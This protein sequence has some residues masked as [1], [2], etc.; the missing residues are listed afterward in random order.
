MQRQ[1]LLGVV[2]S[3]LFVGLEG[4]SRIFS[5]V[6]FAVHIGEGLGDRLSVVGDVLREEWGVYLAYGVVAAIAT[7]LLWRLREA[8][9]VRD[10]WSVIWRAVVVYVPVSIVV[11][12]FI[13][14]G[15]ALIHDRPMFFFGFEVIG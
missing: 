12:F 10:L 14:L 8:W 13:A 9:T 15:S 7:Y 3:A 4:V 2:V 5:L 11:T 6:A 1:W